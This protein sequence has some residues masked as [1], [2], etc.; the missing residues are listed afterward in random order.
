MS[1]KCPY[2]TD[3]KKCKLSGQYC[4]FILYPDETLIDEYWRLCPTYIYFLEKRL[5]EGEKCLDL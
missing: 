5:S 3:T 2:L 4:D 1:K